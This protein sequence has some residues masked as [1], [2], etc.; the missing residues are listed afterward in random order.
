MLTDATGVRLTPGNGGRD[1]LGNG[2]NGGECC[3][4]EC[5]FLR[6]CTAEDWAS[7]CGDCDTIECPHCIK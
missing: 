6:C 5:D 7:R 4:D 2:A 1:C 3:C